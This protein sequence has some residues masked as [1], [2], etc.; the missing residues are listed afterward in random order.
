MNKLLISGNRKGQAMAGLIVQGIG[1]IIDITALVYGLENMYL[2]DFRGEI[3]PVI[4]VIV[5]I[6]GLAYSLYKISLEGLSYSTEISVY[7][8]SIKGRGKTAKFSVPQ[9]FNISIGDIQNVDTIKAGGARNKDA[10]FGV[11]VHTQYANYTCYMKN[12]EE[13]RDKIMELVNAQKAN[14]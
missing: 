9:E 10:A 8:G 5:G 7:E 2:Y 4:L 11:V 1:L 14:V 3:W 6:A 12:G 13:V